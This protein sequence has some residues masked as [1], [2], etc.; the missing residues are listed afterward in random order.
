MLTKD[1]ALSMYF[2]ACWPKQTI[3]RAQNWLIKILNPSGR[4]KFVVSS[5]RRSFLAFKTFSQLF[6]RQN[7]TITLSLI[8]QDNIMTIMTT[9]P[10]RILKLKSM[11]KIEIVANHA[12]F[13]VVTSYQF[14]HNKAFIIF[15]LQND[16]HQDNCHLFAYNFIK[17]NCLNI[18][19]KNIFCRM[20]VKNQ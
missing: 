20:R 7:F 1:S 12:F 8:L 5:F 11:I 10:Y 9:S 17:C 15:N 4:S 3:V 18:P 13:S 14:C 16:F 6:L 19:A 2:F